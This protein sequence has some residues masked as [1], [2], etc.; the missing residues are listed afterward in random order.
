MSGS[1][2]ATSSTGAGQRRCWIY[3]LVGFVIGVGV[4]M[5]ICKR[6]SLWN[7]P[8]GP[9]GDCVHSDGSVYRRNVTQAYCRQICP[10]CTWVQN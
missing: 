5:L 4:G 6:I 9:P 2:A 7:L 10:S 3:L 1:E 8:P